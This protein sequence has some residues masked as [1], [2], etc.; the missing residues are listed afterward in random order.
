MVLW[1]VLRFPDV[2]FSMTMNMVD[3]V[4]KRQGVFSGQTDEDGLA[5]GTWKLTMK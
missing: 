2:P 1:S 4:S 3:L 5:D